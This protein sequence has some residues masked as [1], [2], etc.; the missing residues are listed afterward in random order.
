M[1]GVVT[2]VVLLVL[3][4]VGAVG[5]AVG[6]CVAVLQHRGRR[7]EGARADRAEEARDHMADQLAGAREELARSSAAHER[8]AD[9]ELEAASAERIATRDT[10]RQQKKQARDA[11]RAAGKAL[12]E[13]KR[14]AS[15]DARDR[16]A[17]EKK[18]L[19]EQKRQRKAAE[20]AARRKK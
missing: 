9:I 8:L 18:M 16:K 4:G 1:F 15:K 19:D 11:D 7:S 20:R 17:H 10:L 13:Q 2:D 12:S 6:A 3:T 14:Q 5:T